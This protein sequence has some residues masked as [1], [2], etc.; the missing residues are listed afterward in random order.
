[1]PFA[2]WSIDT[3]TNQSPPAPDGSTSILVC[4]DVTTK[5]AEVGTIPVLDSHHT[6]QWFHANVVCRYGVP[7]LVRSDQGTEYQGDFHNY[8]LSL[9]VCHRPIATMNPRANG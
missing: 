4:V 9:G 8:L 2:C 5:W 1:M 7:Q 6:A 3:I